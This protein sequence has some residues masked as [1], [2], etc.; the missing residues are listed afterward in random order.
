MPLKRSKKTSKKAINED[1]YSKVRRTRIENEAKEAKAKAK[2][3]EDAKKEE[4]RKHKIIFKYLTK[5]D[6]RLKESDMT[7]FWVWPDKPGF[8]KIIMSYKEMQK[9]IYSDVDKYKGR[10][11]AHFAIQLRHHKHGQTPLFG[12]KDMWMGISLIVRKIDNTGK[13]DGKHTAWGCDWNW[14]TDDFKITKFSFK[15]L[16][17]MMRYVNTQSVRC[18]S[19]GGMPLSIV[20]EILDEAGA[21]IKDVL[22]PLANV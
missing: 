3:A 6:A 12:Q 13:L 15:F 22:E 18:E 17:R 1:T 5:L 2:A 14:L 4:A 7:H 11:I 10:N 20:M 19:I 16:E 8:K 9:H 21:K